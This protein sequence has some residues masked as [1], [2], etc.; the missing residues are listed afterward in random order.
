MQR[1]QTV[2]KNVDLT[3]KPTVPVVSALTISGTPGAT[4]E[5]DDKTV[6]QIDGNGNFHLP[7][8][9]AGRH[10]V[11]L[12]KPN[13]EARKAEI[14]ANPPSDAVLANL[15]LQPAFATLDFQGATKNVTVKYRRVGDPQFREANPS[16]KLSLPPGDYE[17]EAEAVGFN[18]F[19]TTVSL[20]NGETSVQLKLVPTPHYEFQD[21]NQIT[22]EGLWVKTKTGGRLVNLKPGFLHENLVFARPGKTLFRNKKVEWQ[23]EDL[24]NHA[25]VLYSLESESQKLTRKL[26]VGQTTT[27]TIEAQVDAKSAGEGNSLSLHVRVESARIRITN[28]KG[29]VMD[30]Y[31]AK[32]QDFSNAQIGIR[33]DSLFIVRS[34]N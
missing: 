33:T 32:G 8:I 5:F 16:S 13:Y 27:D 2:S 12:T 26:A 19:D 30:D 34:D 6:G 3:P 22:D 1:R 15:A 14:F 20:P 28:D 10:T 21:T 7:N 11:T 29:E 17:I 23:I 25:R 9:T 31:I 24:E 4:V 18:R